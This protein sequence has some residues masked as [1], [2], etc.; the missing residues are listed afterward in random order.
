M[1]ELSHDCYDVQM[2]SLK[3]GVGGGWRRKNKEADCGPQALKKKGH[4]PIDH[5]QNC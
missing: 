4:Y 3:F 2:H 5:S 1:N